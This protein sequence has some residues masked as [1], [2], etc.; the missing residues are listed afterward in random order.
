MSNLELYPPTVVVG[1]AVAHH[2]LR[3][4]KT[5]ELREVAAMPHLLQRLETSSL[6][7]QKY[8]GKTNPQCFP[9]VEDRVKALA[10][11]DHQT[12]NLWTL[13]LPHLLAKK[14]LT[15]KLLSL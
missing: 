8:R 2:L 15:L 7:L 13:H 14:A 5:G 6:G 4:C 3:S 9:I 10:T 1:M 12:P 11:L